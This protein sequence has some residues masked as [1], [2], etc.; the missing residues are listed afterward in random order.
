MG[1]LPSSWIEKSN[2]IKHFW[3]VINPLL[4]DAPH[5]HYTYL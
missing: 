3:C 1:M 2:A 5:L 4:T